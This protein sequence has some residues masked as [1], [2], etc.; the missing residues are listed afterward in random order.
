MSRIE[1]EENAWDTSVRIGAQ[2]RCEFQFARD[3]D[4]QQAIYPARTRAAG[5]DVPARGPDDLG[6]GKHFQVRGRPGDFASVKLTVVDGDVRVATECNGRVTEWCSQQGWARHEYVVKG[7]FQTK[8]RLS[9]QMV[10]GTPGLFSCTVAVG[11]R[12][13]VDSDYC[14]DFFQICVDGDILQAYYPDA[15]PADVPGQVL[16]QPPDGVGSAEQFVI[17]AVEY[18]TEFDIFLDL[19]AEDRRKTVYWVPSAAPALAN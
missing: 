17:K 12:Q 6:A 16:V 4:P 19:N 2:G 9:M 10:A 13:F 3:A 14:G 15:A 1:D 7:T 8:Q 18:G 5:A 11:S